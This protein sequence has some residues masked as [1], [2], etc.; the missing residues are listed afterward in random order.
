MGATILAI[1]CMATTFIASPAAAEPQ[2]AAPTDAPLTVQ[3]ESGQI[4][5]FATDRARQFLG[6]PYAKPPVG[7]LR[8]AAPQPADKWPG[9]R[10]TT[11]LGNACPQ[12]SEI[13]GQQMSEDC[14]YLNVTTPR[15]QSPDTQLPV[16]VWWHGGG[17][18]TGS[19]GQYDAQRLADE[20]NVIVITAN[21]RLGILGYFGLPQLPGS[22]NYGLADQLHSLEWTRDNAAHFGGDPDN[23][24]VFGESAGGMATC[25]ALTSPH[26]SELIDKA[27]ISSGSCQLDWP[28]G[29]QYP[30]SPPQ[31]PYIP[32][33]EG[34]E[35]GVQTSSELGCAADVLDCMRSKPVSDLI[36]H[37]QD[38]AN[39]LAYGTELLPQNPATAIEQGRFAQV[40][41]ISGGNRNEARSFVAGAMMYDPGKITE[42]TYPDLLNNAFGEHAPAVAE[43]YPWQQYGS[44]GLAWATVIT[45]SSWSCPTQRANHQIAA[46]T[47]VYP[48]EFADPM[49]PNVN[50]VFVPQFPQEA[51]HATDLPYL[52]DLG[53][54]RLLLPGPQSDLAHSMIRY[55]TTFAHTGNPNHEG[56][57]A[58]E[59]GPGSTLKLLPG[60]TAPANLAAEHQCGFWDSLVS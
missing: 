2:T 31:T 12:S 52:F 44:A 54:N 29:T 9:V 18:T 21:Y 32:Q 51:A 46:H 1:V 37:T 40:P 14:L 60:A 4:R 59:A 23:V 10:D 19:G 26:A 25:A 33:G 53:G 43:R 42:A 27:I 36:P 22:G 6:I 41:V 49:A 24:T 47:T 7:D 11:T 3:T 50:A 5:G 28:A 34:V 48:Y 30:T 39:H 57:P 55:W 20:G 8:W 16:M 56:A 38:F 17:Y 58:W 35:D 45:D 15:R 13:P